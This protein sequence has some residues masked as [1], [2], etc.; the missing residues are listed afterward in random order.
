ME[1]VYGRRSVLELLGGERPVKKVL[2]AIGAKRGEALHKIEN[3]ARRRGAEVTE[4][5]RRELD[6]LTGGAVHQG[7]LAIAEAFEY[8]DLH[9]LLASLADAES[10]VLLA[11]D[12]ITDPHNVGALIRTADATGVA[13]VITAKRRSA[14][15]TPAVYKASAGAVEHI[16]IAQAS[17]LVN[18]IEE[19]KRAGFWVYGADSAAETAL[20]EVELTGKVLIVLGSE[21]MGLSR[22]VKEKCDFLVAIPMA[23][24]VESL[25]VSVAG[26]LLMYEAF[27]KKL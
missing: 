20:F 27:R 4:V 10:A 17:N 25:N 22:L 18:A 19:A 6:D 15:I 13:G 7:V 23:G 26:A 12:E 24:K 8:T 11:L 5:D 21:S 14:P 1:I 2:L 16:A 3:L 9:E